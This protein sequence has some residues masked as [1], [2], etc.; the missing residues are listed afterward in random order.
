MAEC[1]FVWAISYPYSLFNEIFEDMVDCDTPFPDNL[2]YF[3]GNKLHFTEYCKSLIYKV[4][5]IE[6]ELEIIVK[7]HV[8]FKK[9]IQN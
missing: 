3:N 5:T 1:F 2:R 6:N 4:E 7:T 9:K 8:N